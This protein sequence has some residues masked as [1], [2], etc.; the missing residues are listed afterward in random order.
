MTPFLARSKNAQNAPRT[1]RAACPYFTP[2]P[3]PPALP[4]PNLTV[5]GPVFEGAEVRFFG[6]FW[7]GLTRRELLLKIVM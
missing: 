2:N 3:A 7:P 6:V 5:Y 1:R 4:G